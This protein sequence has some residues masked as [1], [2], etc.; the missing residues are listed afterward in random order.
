MLDENWNLLLQNYGMRFRVTALAERYTVRDCWVLSAYD[1]QHATVYSVGWDGYE[2][3][4]LQCEG[5]QFARD[6]IQYIWSRFWG[7]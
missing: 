3:P 4:K 7:G 6:L 5:G 1:E 2:P